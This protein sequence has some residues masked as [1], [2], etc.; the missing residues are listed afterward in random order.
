MANPNNVSLVI[1]AVIGGW[2]FLWSTL[3]L[4]DWAQFTHGS[5]PRPG[6]F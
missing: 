2:H 5:I 6:R 1:G 4:L 3:V